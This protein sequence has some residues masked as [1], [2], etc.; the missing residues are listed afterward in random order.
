[1]REGLRGVEVRVGGVIS[2]HEVGGGS[3][4]CVEG[5]GCRGALDQHGDHGI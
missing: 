5:E 1:V 4:S 2:G 3:S